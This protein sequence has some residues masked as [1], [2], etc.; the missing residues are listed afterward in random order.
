[1]VVVLVEAAAE[2]LAFGADAEALVLFT[3]R[4][5]NPGDVQTR[6]FALFRMLKLPGEHFLGAWCWANLLNQLEY[7][8]L[9]LRLNH[10]S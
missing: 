9:V 8:G 10:L 4:W 6:F 3:P 1:M 5:A 7:L 2:T